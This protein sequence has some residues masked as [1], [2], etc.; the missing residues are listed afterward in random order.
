MNGGFESDLLSVNRINDNAGLGDD[1]HPV[2]VGVVLDQGAVPQTGLHLHCETCVRSHP[3]HLVVVEMMV[4]LWH[5]ASTGG[6][7]DDGASEVLTWQVIARHLAVPRLQSKRTTLLNSPS[8]TTC[9]AGTTLSTSLLA[10]LP[11]SSF[12]SAFD[13]ALCRASPF[14]VRLR[15][16]GWWPGGRRQLPAPKKTMFISSI[17]IV[18]CEL[19]NKHFKKKS[20]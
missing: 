6:A 11:S 5:L 1:L 9:S 15:G 20:Q 3:I 4:N 14:V 13:L 2:D 18:T 19:V 10:L 17:N 16:F 7:G 8:S 12:S